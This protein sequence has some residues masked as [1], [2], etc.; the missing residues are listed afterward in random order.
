MADTNPT[1]ADSF[2]IVAQDIV[3]RFG[4]LTAVNSVNFTIS[5]GEVVGFLGPNGAG[6]TTAIRLLTCTSPLTSGLLT[7]FGLDVSR[8]PREIKAQIGVVPQDNNYDPDLSVLANLLTFGRY[9]RLD[10]DLVRTRALE[11]LEF[12]QLT[13]KADRNVDE[14]SGG[15]KRRLILA[16]SLINDPRLLVLDEPTTGLDPQARRLIWQRIRELR[17]RGK[18]IIITTHYMDEAEQVCD[19]LLV[20]DNG[21]IIAE[22]TPKGLIEEHAG[23]EILEVVPETPDTPALAAILKACTRYQQLGDKYEIFSRDCPGMLET[24]RR[25]ITLRAY[26]MRRA[27][28]EDVF[29]RLTGREL[30]D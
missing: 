20:M 9:F 18:T 27:T 12:V 25:T 4:E 3:K 19:R 1:Q 26:G 10:P 11:L 15:M 8:A 13:E 16:R 7:V 28:L 5:A 2:L 24:I 30:R 6:K 22:G 17:A 14:L 23:D 29:I 21:E